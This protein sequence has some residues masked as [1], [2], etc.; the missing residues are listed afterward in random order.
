MT[1]DPARQRR[2]VLRALAIVATALLA[3]CNTVTTLVKER[4]T[5]GD[6][7][8]PMVRAV[9]GLGDLP[10]ASAYVRSGDRFEGLVILGSIDAGAVQNWYGREGFMLQIKGDRLTYSRGLPVDVLETYP[11][12]LAFAEQEYDCGDGIR[13]AEPPA[14]FYTRLRNETGFLA[15][16]RQ[17]LSCRIEP[18][19]TPGY[20]GDALR[21]DESY[22]FLPHPQPQRRTRWLHPQ[23]RQLL[24]LEY[25]E[26]PLAPEVTISWLKPAA[27]R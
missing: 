13:Y 9:T 14:L 24:R 16:L 3:A 4:M 21:V 20:A 18:I 7:G 19:V 17:D 8:S 10:F 15:E 1:T 22:L 23:T 25:A 2:A 27:R 6:Q 5:E 12:A 26:H 11:A